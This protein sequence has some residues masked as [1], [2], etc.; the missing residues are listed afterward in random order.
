MRVSVS[1]VLAAVMCVGANTA[2]AVPIVFSDA[3]PDNIG[4]NGSRIV[5]FT[6]DDSYQDLSTVQIQF[7]VG[8]VDE[9]FDVTIN[10]TQNVAI[11][12]F[13]TN[14]GGP[15]GIT[16]GLNAPWGHDGT[17]PRVVSQISSSAITLTGLVNQGDATYTP[18]TVVAPAPPVTLPVFIDGTN[19]FRID[20]NNSSG[21]GGTRV[22]AISGTVDL[23]GPPPTPVPVPNFN[24]ELDNSGNPSTTKRGMDQVMAWT[25]QTA[26]TGVEVYAGGGTEGPLATYMSGGSAFYQI[27]TQPIAEGETYRLIYDGRSNC[28]GGDE[29]KASFFYDNGGHVEI[30][31]F[32]T[33][34]LDASSGT[35]LMDIGSLAFTA[36]AGEAY[37]GQNLGIK[38]AATAGAWMGVD[39][40]RLTVTAPVTVIPE[41]M[42]MLAVGLAVTGLGG[43]VR[44]RRTA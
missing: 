2:S 21:P 43:Y 12:R 13:D 34:G 39:N 38:F 6:L 37:L 18:L 19:T 22:M 40:V 15:I 42:T 20:N 3:T 33:S 1:L 28:C 29:L 16:P 5:T 11:P 23:T 9:G 8:Q 17:R 36:Q 35:W 44:K 10:G 25:E 7:D 24:F 26:T 30:A 4:S 31:S 32:T 27:L 14:P 41:P